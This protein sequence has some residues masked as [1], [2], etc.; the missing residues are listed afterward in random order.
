MLRISK[1]RNSLV[2]SCKIKPRVNSPI[3]HFRLQRKNTNIYLIGKNQQRET[4]LSSFIRSWDHLKYYW[5]HD[6]LYPKKILF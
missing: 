4:H 1:L 5:T 2:L 6:Q 3:L